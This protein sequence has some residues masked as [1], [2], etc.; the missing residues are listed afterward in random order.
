MA[1][2]CLYSQPQPLS[3]LTADQPSCIAP[4]SCSACPGYPLFLLDH[5]L[6]CTCLSE[7][8][9]VLLAICFMHGHNPPMAHRDLKPDNILVE[10]DEAT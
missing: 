2:A 8:A 7:V 6:A 10:F 1:R 5:G 9:T 3:H 4:S